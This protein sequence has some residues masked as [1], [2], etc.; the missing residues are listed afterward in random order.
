MTTYHEF[1]E[2]Q[3]N[4]AIESARNHFAENDVAKMNASR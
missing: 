2:S 3:V 1:D 4:E